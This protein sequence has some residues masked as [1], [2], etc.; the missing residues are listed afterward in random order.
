MRIYSNRDRIPS[1]TTNLSLLPPYKFLESIKE[2]KESRAPSS[3]GVSNSAADA[4]TVITDAS[5]VEGV[6]VYHLKVRERAGTLYADPGEAILLTFNQK[7]KLE[8]PGQYERFKAYITDAAQRY[9]VELAR[10]E[11]SGG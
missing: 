10:E 9:F 2:K 6:P 5:P 11:M 7:M 3:S 4:G 1:N 8:N